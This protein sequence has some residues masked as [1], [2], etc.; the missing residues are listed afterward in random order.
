MAWSDD[1]MTLVFGL[2]ALR[3]L[4]DP[5][6][7]VAEAESW[8]AALGAAA[9]DDDELRTFLDRENV[10]PGFVPGER[11]L[12]G[13]LVTVRQ[14]VT[15]DRH[16]FVGATEEA[17]AMAESVGWEYLPVEEA[18]EKAGWGLVESESER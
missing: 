1:T 6:T 8:T 3:R 11:G 10:E 17:R 7:A 14:R 12:I 4:S 9:E 2:G 5:R 16:V 15:T 18:A 13:G